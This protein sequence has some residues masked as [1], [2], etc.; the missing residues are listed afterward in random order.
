MTHKPSHSDGSLGYLFTDDS[1]HSLFLKI[2]LFILALTG[3]A[4]LAVVLFPQLDVTAATYLFGFGF[5]YVTL[6][7]SALLI[8]FDRFRW[9]MVALVAGLT[10]VNLGLVLLT[11]KTPSYVFISAFNLI[12]MAGVLLSPAAG[13]YT[14]FAFAVGILSLELGLLDKVS[15]IG[16]QN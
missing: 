9:A 7:T 1:T 15:L 4:H 13:V 2:I 3:V 10:V 16:I 14:F 11:N 6:G 8:Y 12:M 5:A